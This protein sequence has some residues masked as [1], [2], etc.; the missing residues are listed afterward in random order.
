METKK[1]E[2]TL[3]ASHSLKTTLSK[4]YEAV[5]VIPNK[6]KEGIEKQNISPVAPQ[7]WNYIDCNGSMDAEFTLEVCIPVDKKGTDTEFISYKELQDFS[8][9]AH[10][11][12]GPWSD[13]VEV[14]PKLFGELEK[15]GKAYTGNVREVYHNCDFEDQNK[16]VTEIQIEV[17]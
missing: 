10:T 2:K 9:E 14:Y 16:C 15:Q 1:I 8:C 5:G 13:F 17:K 6:V 11:H 4:I 3:V 12:N 7:I